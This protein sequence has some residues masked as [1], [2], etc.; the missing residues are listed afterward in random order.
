MSSLV[1]VRHGQASFN[2]GDYDR[3]SPRG[4]EQ[5]RL[6][7]RYWL[8]LGYRP[9]RVFLGPRKRHAQTW[10]EV[11]AVYEDRGLAVPEAKV[12]PELDEHEAAKMVKAEM[13]DGAG[14]PPGAEAG[15]IN[16]VREFKPYFRLYQ[17][18]TRRWVRGELIRPGFESWT[19]FQRRVA[20]GMALVR[21]D[22]GRGERVA[23]FTSGG[24]ASMAAGTAL[25]LDLERILEWSW[26][27]YN[28]AQAE[29]R[30]T[31]NRLT[32]VSFNAVPH[33]ASADLH[34][35]V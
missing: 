26:F 3:L 2:S 29:F 16:L 32:L 22:S 13:A 11:A 34:T 21:Q 4:R 31:A 17:D 7:A 1:L 27:M 14:S 25:G 28:A 9:D 18:L 23:V 8:A 20:E 15:E 5:S 24:T 35:L 33:L 6:L 12:L 30:F 10:H 19:G